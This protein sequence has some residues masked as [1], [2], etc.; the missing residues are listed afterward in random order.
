MEFTFVRGFVLF[1]ALIGFGASSTTSGHQKAQDDLIGGGG[2]PSCAPN[3]GQF[4]GM[5]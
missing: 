3:S 4:C 2:A 5:Q 1:I